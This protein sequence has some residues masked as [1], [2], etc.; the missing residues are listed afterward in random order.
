MIVLVRIMNTVRNSDARFKHRNKSISKY[1]YHDTRIK[2][3]RIALTCTCIMGLSWA[4]GIFS[5]GDASTVVQW[6]F[7]V[8]N[9]LQ[10]FFIFVFHTLR[11]QDIQKEVDSRMV[12]FYPGSPLR[13]STSSQINQTFS[14]QLKR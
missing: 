12:K 13:S 1:H 4:I 7:T 5:L 3:A 14:M 10:G 11:N 6:V 8:L 2:M 9:S